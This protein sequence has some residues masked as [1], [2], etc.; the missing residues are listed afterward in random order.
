M[1]RKR[2]VVNQLSSFGSGDCAQLGHGECITECSQPYPIEKLQ[3]YKLIALC[4]GPMHNAVITDENQVFTW[5]TNDENALGHDQDEWIPNPINIKCKIVKISC[6]ESHTT[7]LT[8]L[9]DVWSWG[10][11]RDHSGIIDGFVTSIHK[12]D[13]SCVIDIASCNNSCFVLTQSNLYSWGNVSKDI[14][15][16]ET[17]TNF[18]HI[19]AGAESI[20]GID[21]EEN[22]Y[23]KGINNYC[24]IGIDSK[25]EP[26]L[27]FQFVMENCKKVAPSVHH[28]L[29]LKT[30]GAVYSCG[31][32]AYGRLGH[33]NQ[34]DMSL[35]LQII[36][37]KNIVDIAVG[38]THSCCI[39]SNKE[40]FTFGNGLLLQLGNGKEDDVFEPCK[41][42]DDILR[43][44]CGSQHTIC[45]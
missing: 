19:F 37:L 40:L 30:N 9:G 5:G 25:N 33:G 35:P 7:A 31:K 45:Y 21:M 27:D 38:E 6:G 18:N 2:D 15:K 22:L 42:A 11:F 16:L 32:G 10:N 39:N 29:F 12:I 17:F 14:T 1:K 43:V 28:S 36:A 26:I 41:M 8:I 4:C 20:F 3:D 13:I 44:A 24:Q 23:G 34:L